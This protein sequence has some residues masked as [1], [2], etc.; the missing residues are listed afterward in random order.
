MGTG[1]FFC[2]A[3]PNLWF[4]QMSSL[5]KVQVSG[6][7]DLLL[8]ISSCQLTLL[9]TFWQFGLLSWGLGITCICPKTQGHSLCAALAFTLH[10][11][12]WHLF[13]GKSTVP[14][15]LTHYVFFF[16]SPPGVEKAIREFAV[17]SFCPRQTLSCLTQVSFHIFHLNVLSARTSI[18]RP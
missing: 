16:F 13:P 17:T 5:R 11:L 4:W 3:V 1:C 9:C 10:H 14:K 7:K 6:L 18:I 8:L 15:S 2:S 12:W